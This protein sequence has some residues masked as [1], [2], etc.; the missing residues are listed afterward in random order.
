MKG[1]SI[2]I[3]RLA[4]LV[5]FTVPALTAGTVNLSFVSLSQPGSNMA[6]VGNASGIIVQ[7]GFTLTSPDAS[8]DV[9]QASSPNLPG[10]NVANTALFEFYCSAPIPTCTGQPDTVTAGGAVFTA[11]SIQLA[12][13]L[14]GGSGTFTVTLTG[15]RLDNSPVTQTFTVSYG[16]PTTLQTF[17]FTNFTNLVSLTLPQGANNGFYGSQSGAYQFDNLNLTTGQPL[18]AVNGTT[19]AVYNAATFETGGIAPNEFLTLMG[20]GLGPETGV[21]GSMSTRLGGASVLMGGMPAYLTYAQDRQINVLAPFNISGLENTT[22]QVTYDGLAGNT[23]TVPVVDSS[24]GIFTQHYGPGQAWVSNQDQTFNSASNAAPR[25]THVAFW[26]TGQGRVNTTL[27]DGVQPSGPPYPTPMLPVSVSLGGV[28]VP[29][30]NI[31]FDGL[32]YSGEVQINLLIPA[33]AP[34]GS[35]VPLVVAIGAIPSRTDATIAIQ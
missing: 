8:W 4:E 25:G 21:S 5:L 22:I 35:A 10:L 9:W 15:T 34:T 29:T 1:I 11:N 6:S 23:V 16:T 28:A 20:S 33:D 26:V 32:I 31:L 17:S 18:I 24:P 3:G 30:E 19:P 12:P 2:S 14:A 27:A 7:S 13:L